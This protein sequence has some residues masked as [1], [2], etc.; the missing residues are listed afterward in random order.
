MVRQTV[1]K[2]LGPANLNYSVFIL[3]LCFA[4][5]SVERL[6]VDQEVA[7][8]SQAGGEVRPKALELHL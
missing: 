1:D 5:R 4:L 7:N 3:F 6:T 8:S 2:L